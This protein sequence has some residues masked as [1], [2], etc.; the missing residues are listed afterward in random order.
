MMST[1]KTL[2]L[3]LSALA[4]AGCNS[5]P[6]KEVQVPVVSTDY[7]MTEVPKSFTDRLVIPAPPARKDYV[8]LM[9]EDRETALANYNKRLLKVISDANSDRASLRKWSDSQKKEV[10]K[11]NGY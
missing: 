6:V 9:C 4:L 10:E 8:T 11:K 2:L 1:N 3:A 5:M 7:V